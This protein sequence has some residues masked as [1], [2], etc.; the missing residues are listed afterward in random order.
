[1]PARIDADFRRFRPAPRLSGTQHAGTVAS[2]LKDELGDQLHFFGWKIKALA[3]NQEH[4]RSTDSLAG[5]YNARRKPA[6]PECEG[7]H[8]SCQNC[9]RFAMNWRKKVL[10][11]LGMADPTKEREPEQGLLF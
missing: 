5:S 4:V 10:D 11:L 9:I 8:P 6:L 1:M 3:M 2:T 7:L